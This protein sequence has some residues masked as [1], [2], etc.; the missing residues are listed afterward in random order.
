VCKKKRIGCPA[1]TNIVSI[2]STFYKQLL[3]QYSFI[4]KFQTQN[5]VREKLQKALSYEKG[6]CKMLMKLCPGVNFINILQAAYCIKVFRT[7]FMRLQF[8]VVI[9]CQKMV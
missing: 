5:I 3:R 1:R 6:A 4:K 7:A 9:F 8:G 2:L